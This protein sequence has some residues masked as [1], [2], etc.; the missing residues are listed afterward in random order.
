MIK[1]N[2]YTQGVYNVI[3]PNKYSGSVPIVYRSRP[4]YMIM[5]WLDLNP[6]VLTWSSE[7][8]VVPYRSPQDN[9]YHRYFVDFSCQYKDSSGKV[10]NIMIEYKPKKFTIPPVKSKRMSDKTFRNLCET[11]VKNQAK[12]K[13]AREFAEARNATFMVLTEEHIGL[14]NNK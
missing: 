12:W 13:A 5:R 1:S 7:S 2:Y 10:S 8:T 14:K 9:S 6:N 4:E 3:T 11:W